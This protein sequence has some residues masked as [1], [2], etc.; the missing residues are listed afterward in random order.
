MALHSHC[1][2]L[3]KGAYRQPVW[4]SVRTRQGNLLLREL[5]CHTVL[6]APAIHMGGGGQRPYPAMGMR[7]M[8]RQGERLLAALPGKG[9]GY[10][11]PSPQI[12]T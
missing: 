6:S 1:P 5:A 11:A 10:P 12:R 9:T 8:L 4:K 7:Q 3:S 2:A